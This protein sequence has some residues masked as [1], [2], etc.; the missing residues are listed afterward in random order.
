[1]SVLLYKVLTDCSEFRGTVYLYSTRGQS[2]SCLGE[3]PYKA[4]VRPSW[5]TASAPPGTLNSSNPTPKLPDQC[6][7]TYLY[8]HRPISKD[9]LH[10]PPTEK[11]KQ[12]QKQ[13]HRTLPLFTTV[14]SPSLLPTSRITMA[15]QFAT[16]ALN[17]LPPLVQNYDTIIGRVQRI[18]I[19]G[20]KKSRIRNGDGYQSDHEYKYISRSGDMDRPRG[21]DR[22][23]LRSAPL[24]QQAG[25]TR[26]RP[27]SVESIPRDFPPPGSTYSPRQA[28]PKSAGHDPYSPG[29]G[30]ASKRDYRPKSQRRV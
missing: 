17:G 22:G 20:R 2:S 19:P 14:P 4:C 3:L 1:M 21:R 13:K 27:S 9:P 7:V 26:Q 29:S 6:T 11:Q 8:F 12:K 16:L 18:S 25:Y 30:R 5:P 28:G 10:P 23:G 15:Q 24:A